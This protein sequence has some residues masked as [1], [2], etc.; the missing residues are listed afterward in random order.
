MRVT[1]NYNIHSLLREVNQSRERIYNLQKNISTGKRINTISD[2][3]YNI[4]AVMRFRSLIAKNEN[5]KENISNAI[6]FMEMTSKSLNDIGDLLA[7]IKELAVQ[8]VDSTSDEDFQAYA[9]QVNELLQELVGQ[10]NARFKE[11]YLFGGSNVSEAPFSI[12]ADLTSVTTNPN[13]IEGKLQV[14]LGEGKIDQYNVTGQEVFFSGVDVFQ[15]VIDLRDAFQNEDSAQISTLIDE[16]DRSLDQVLQVNA[17]VGAKIN[18][19]DLLTSQY[20]SE[21]VRLKSFLSK[22]EDTD[23]IRA[24]SDLQTEEIALQTALKVLAESVNLSLVDYL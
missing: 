11:R 7:Q 14:E 24:V 5:F 20:D 2:D 4:E 17:K 3:P 13:G 23:M 10:A 8:G 21:S 15:T 19:Y 22:V 18:R 1:Q 16:L 9:T 6:D 12:D